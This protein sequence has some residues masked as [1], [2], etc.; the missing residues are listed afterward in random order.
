MP[1]RFRFYKISQEHL[2]KAK[3]KYCQQH[4]LPRTVLQKCNYYR[5]NDGDDGADIRNKIEVK[6]DYAPKYREIYAEK[7]GITEGENSSP[8][9]DQNLCE[10]VFLQLIRYSLNSSVDLRA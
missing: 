9:A 2:D 10:G 4:F 3:T 7:V 5:G 6:S 8:K 1:H